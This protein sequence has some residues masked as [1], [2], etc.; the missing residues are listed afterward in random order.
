MVQYN[1]FAASQTG[2]S[3]TSTAQVVNQNFKGEYLQ[4]APDGKIY[5]TELGI[6]LITGGLSTLIGS[7][8]CPNS[9]SPTITSNLFSYQSEVFHARQRRHTGQPGQDRDRKWCGLP[10]GL[11]DKG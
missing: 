9:S 2:V 3:I 8:N 10:D 1:V 7:I 5:Y 6:D 11:G 4:L